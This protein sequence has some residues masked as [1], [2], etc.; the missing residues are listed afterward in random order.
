M[1]VIAVVS[2]IL[3][4]TVVASHSWA[5]PPTA[6]PRSADQKQLVRTVVT[7]FGKRLRMVAALAPREVAD[8]AMDEEY[9]PFVSADLLTTW[10]KNPEK[11]PGKRTS[12]PSPERIDISSIRSK[13]HR[14][15]LVKGKVILLTS[16]ERRDGGVFQAN[17]VTMTVAQQHGK[18]VIM[19]YQ[20][21]EAPP[22][23]G[24]SRLPAGSR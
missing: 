10:K 16:Q 13:G 12:S 17:P 20:E 9:S 19:A 8:K 11:A 4:T 18:W 6:V 5:Q 23:L 24:S 21:K 22:L 1:R 7:E 15:Y 3:V 14:A 2:A